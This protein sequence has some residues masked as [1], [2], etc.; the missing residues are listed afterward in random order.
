MTYAAI[1]LFGDDPYGWRLRNVVFGAGTVAVEFLL[2]E[3]LFGC[4][5][6]IQVPST[7]FPGGCLV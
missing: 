5:G 6:Y 7:P 2:G 3:A 1:R 4:D